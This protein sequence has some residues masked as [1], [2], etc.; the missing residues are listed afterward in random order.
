EGLGARDLVDEPK[1]EV[2]LQVVADAGLVEHDR[3][4]EALE[5][6]GAAHAGE[7]ENLG[8]AD[9]AGREDHL[10][11][12]A[13]GSRRAVLPPVHARRAWAVKRDPFH[14]A[15]G[16]EPQIG[17]VEHGLE[18]TA[19]RRP[20]APALLVDVEDATALVV[21]GVE[22][23]DALDAGLFRRRAERIEDVPA[24]A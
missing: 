24:H 1:L 8:R 4:A 22:I 23:G 17:A 5:L 18:K 11:A 20:A 14:Q 6:L 21:A 19:R 12:S 15:V 16:L 3:N 2:V 7:L 10:A 13:R 9:R